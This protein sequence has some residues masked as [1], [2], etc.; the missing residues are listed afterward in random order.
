M[1]NQTAAHSVEAA[2][3]AM[4]QKF[5]DHDPE[6]V[7]AALHANCTVWDLFV[8]EL[9][10]GRE[11]RR[12]FH[13]DDQAQAQARGA[14][15]WSIDTPVIDVW[16][17]TAIARYYLRFSYEPPFPVSG[18]VRI[19][20]VLRRDGEGWVIVHHHEGLLPSGVPPTH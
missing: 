19:T 14:L 16:G 2:I 1:S 12:K 7:E 6:G 4:F 8:P 15:T 10:V 20:S 18:V 9:I 13:A 5:A 3:R 11:A 17:D